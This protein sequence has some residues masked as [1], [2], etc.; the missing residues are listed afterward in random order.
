MDNLNEREI[1][2]ILKS[3]RKRT[4]IICSTLFTEDGF[5]ITLEKDK[6]EG[7]DD[8]DYQSICAISAGIVA[9]AEESVQ[10]IRKDNFIKQISIQAG[11]PLDN[12]SFI[13]HLESITKN[14]RLGIMFPLFLNLGVILFELKQTIQQL[15]KYFI[16]FDQNE[17]LNS[18]STVP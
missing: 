5:V 4:G 16:E 12:E 15:S 11:D 18:V 6:I 14:V 2:N 10:I 3:F 13:I 1:Q 8:D 9:L 17:N 7:G